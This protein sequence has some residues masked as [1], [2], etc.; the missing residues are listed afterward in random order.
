VST[1]SQRSLAIKLAQSPGAEACARVSVRR[2]TKSYGQAHPVLNDVTFGAEPG[3]LVALVGANGAGKSTLLRCLVRL[4]EPT[5]GHVDIGG[6]DVTRA[7]QAQLRALRSRVG[8]V[9]QKYHLIPRLS[10]F[11]NVLLGALGRG[12]PLNWWP[13][14]APEA[15]RLEALACLSRVGLDGFGSRRADE[16]SGGQQQRVAVARMLMQRPVLVLADEP[17]ASL[18][19]AAG[20]AVMEL[21]RSIAR[22]RGLAV[23]V[24]L[25]QLDLAQEFSDRVIGLNQGRVSLDTPVSAWQS[26]EI[27]ALYA[28]PA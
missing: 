6:V 24:A 12:G 19:P 4:I 15:D 28:T 21:L 9:F 26:A 1:T 22:E 10:A 14:T 7:S 5:T 2:L 11:H 8:F 13:A 17:V 27:S 20:V 3:Q 25:H 23:I 18:D 16:L